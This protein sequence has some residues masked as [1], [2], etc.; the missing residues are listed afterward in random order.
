[1]KIKIDRYGKE[2]DTD[3]LEL[4]INEKKFRIEVE[5]I[6]NDSFLLITKSDFDSGNGIEIS[7]VVSNQIE[8]R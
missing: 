2:I 7:P 4:Y 6:K 1:M 5:T 8:I 3:F